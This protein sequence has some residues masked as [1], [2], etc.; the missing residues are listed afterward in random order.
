MK[1]C[2]SRVIFIVKAKDSYYK[3]EGKKLLDPPLGPKRYWSILNSFLGNKKMPNIPP[4]CE[5]GEIVTDYS[6]VLPLTRMMWYPI[7]S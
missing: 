5:N 6:N 1:K 2:P 7:F 3:K 4:L